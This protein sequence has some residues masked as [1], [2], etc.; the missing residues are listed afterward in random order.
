MLSDVMG[1]RSRATD[2]R[3]L[4][5]GARSKVDAAMLEEIAEELDHEARK[6]E[7]SG[8]AARAKPDNDT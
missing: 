1:L 2:C 5:K 7:N 4:A 8:N 6:I 3:A